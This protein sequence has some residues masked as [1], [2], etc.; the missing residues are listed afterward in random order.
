[1]KSKI[2]EIL[3]YIMIILIIITVRIFIITP[4]R[5]EGTSMNKTLNNGDL[6]L[7][8]KLSKIKRYDIIVMKEEKDVIIKRV[9]GLPGESIEIKNNKIYINDEVILDENSFGETNN[10]S[11]ITLAKDEYFVLGDNRLISKDSRY[12]GPIPE[13]NIK[14]KVILRFFPL[15]KIST[16]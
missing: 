13:K 16:L 8:Y 5:V 10:Y 12:F 3:P 1:M 4:V 14:G 15:T 2:K 9:I 6:L 11:Q 7:L